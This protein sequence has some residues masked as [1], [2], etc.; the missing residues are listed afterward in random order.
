MHYNGVNTYIFV[1]N[2]GIQKFNAKD[3]EINLALLCLFNVSKY[4]S[5]AILKKTGLCGYVNDFSVDYH[6]IDVD[7]IL[8]IHKYLMV[9]INIK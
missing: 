7:D 3:S 9:L 5:T 1:N 6:S 2:V 8:V 4:F